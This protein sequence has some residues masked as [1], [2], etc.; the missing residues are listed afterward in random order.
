MIPCSRKQETWSVLCSLQVAQQ[1]EECPFQVDQLVQASSRNFGFSKTIS[2]RVSWGKRGLVKPS[3]PRTS[4]SYS[5][6]YFLSLMSLSAGW[7][8]SQEVLSER[9]PLHTTYSHIACEGQVFILRPIAGKFRQDTWKQVFYLDFSLAQ[10]YSGL[11]VLNPQREVAHTL[12]ILGIGLQWKENLRNVSKL[13]K[14][15]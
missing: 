4:W 2:L 7:N 9:K 12:C 14:L 10:R 13:R 1:V 8:V 5:F 15:L 3:I 6:V 11:K